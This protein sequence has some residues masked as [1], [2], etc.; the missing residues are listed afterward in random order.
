[1][2]DK[3]LN[4]SKLENKKKKIQNRKIKSIKKRFDINERNFLTKIFFDKLKNHNKTIPKTIKP[5][6]NIGL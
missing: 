6:K 2:K 3:V 1:M 5:N 4:S